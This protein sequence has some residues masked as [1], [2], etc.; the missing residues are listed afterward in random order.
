MKAGFDWYQYGGFRESEQS[1]PVTC[2][3]DKVRGGS[4]LVCEKQ[5]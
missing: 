4:E 5:N 1:A 2:G 3:A